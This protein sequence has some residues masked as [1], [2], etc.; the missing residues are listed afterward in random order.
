MPFVWALPSGLLGASPNQGHT[1]ELIKELA[2]SGKA[3]PHIRWQS[4]TDAAEESWGNPLGS[5]N[6]PAQLHADGEA[7]GDESGDERR[8]SGAH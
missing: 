3:S 2:A 4:R 6:E 1:P 5:I 7:N 8:Q